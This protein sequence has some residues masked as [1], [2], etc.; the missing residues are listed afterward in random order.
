MAYTAELILPYVIDV[1]VTAGPDRL[2][3]EVIQRAHSED[4][5]EILGRWVEGVEQ[6]VVD[7]FLGRA[8]LG[9]VLEALGPG[10]R[11]VCAG[12]RDSRH[13]PDCGGPPQ[14]SFF[15]QATDDLAT[16]PRVLLCSRC[17]QTWGYARMTCAGCGE[18][19]SA[20]LNVFSEHGTTSSERGNVVRGLSPGPSVARSDAVFPHM[21]IE[22][23]DT[24]RKYLL[25]VDLAA[26]AGAVPL[27]D[28]MAAIPLDLF[29]RERGYNK[30]ITN[31]MG[32]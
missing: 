25:S 3:S 28:E 24:C 17:G 26:D 18:S 16:G 27:V 8:S 12:P 29:A 4:A 14:L 21:R 13:C 1:S 10:A 15:S 19:E 22:A 32:F 6:P 31:L 23:C 5:R 30:I 11:A 2:R 9:P 20:K 7:R